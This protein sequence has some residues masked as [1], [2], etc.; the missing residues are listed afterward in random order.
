MPMGNRIR[1]AGFHAIS[2]ENAARIIN[3]VNGS[4]PL[5]RGNPVRVGIFGGF[6][7]NAVRRACR[8]T[9]KASDALFQPVFITMQHVNSAV[10]RLKMHWL[11]RVVLCDRFPEYVPERHA[12]PLHHRG[13]RR[14]YLAEWISH[15]P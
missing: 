14:E 8:C 15:S 6:N 4:V 1:R 9:Q 2:A 11:M 10:A 13:E 5:S 12:E 3:V 7:V